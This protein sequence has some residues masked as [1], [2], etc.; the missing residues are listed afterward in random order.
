VA[1]NEDVAQGMVRELALRLGEIDCD[2]LAEP[3]NW[4]S[5][6]VEHAVQDGRAMPTVAQR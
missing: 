6:I 4:W 1:E 2:A 3:E 5:V